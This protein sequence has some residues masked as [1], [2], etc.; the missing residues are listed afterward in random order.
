MFDNENRDF[1]SLEKGEDLTPL[2]LEHT[3]H[4]HTG[5]SCCETNSKSKDMNKIWL[6]VSIFLAGI[7][8][9]AMIFSLGGNK[10]SVEIFK[11][12]VGDTARSVIT[13]VNGENKVY[14]ASEIYANN[15]DS[16]VAIQTEVVTTNIFGQNIAGAAA[17]SGFIISDN[18]YVLTNA[19]VVSDA[20][21]IKVIM[22]DK[23]EYKATLI[24]SEEE[25]DIA[26]LRI[27]S[28]KTF[29]PVILGD[30]DKM[31][32]GEDVVAIG[33]PLGELTFSITKGI[34]SALNRS[35]KVDAYTTLNMFQ[36]DCAVNEGNSGGPVF[37]MYGEVIGIVSA[38]YA[39]ST[40][41]G[42]GFCIPIN[43]VSNIVTDLIDYGKV[44]NK[45]YM[46]ISVTDIDDKMIA[47]YKMVKGAYVAGV[48]EGSCAEKAG[49]KIGDIIVKFDDKEVKSVSE[50][51][52]FKK[53]YRAG[54]SATLKIWRSGEYKDISIIFDEYDEEE[55][56]AIEEKQNE[57]LQQ[58][59]PQGNQDYQQYPDNYNR[60]EL[61]D[62]FWDFF[63]DEF[64]Y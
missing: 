46:G 16:V 43:D 61:E 57:E 30:S 50:L 40:I 59:L 54:D 15:I 19:H 23:S 13:T 37:N 51:L 33:N 36:V 47:T 18:G 35:I 63:M 49:L 2:K 55:V 60:D 56:K 27:E 25:S 45:A 29:K 6:G 5:C 22:S 53:G 52:S 58:Q 28:D 21:S 3:H 9:V 31:I 42:L 26:V 44:T 20:S 32:I 4:N 1:I 10:E 34:V 48:E 62:F 38:K 11:S 17:G 64:G 39:S 24:G 12:G 8:L 14:S 41:E 7:L